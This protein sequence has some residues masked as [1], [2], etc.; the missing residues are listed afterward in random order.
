MFVSIMT[1][2]DSIKK[3]EILKTLAELQIGSLNL[4]V[5]GVSMD[6]ALRPLDRVHLNRGLYL[7]GDI[8]V[9]VRRDFMVIHRLIGWWWYQG[10]WHL[11]TKGDNLE[12]IDALVSKDCIIGKVIS[13]ERNG[14]IFS[15]TFR[16]RFCKW[17]K[18]IGGYIVRRATRPRLKVD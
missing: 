4:T 9:Y 5:Q 3:R 17:L 13:W 6:P 15:E 11:V 2:H 12:H 8:L 16:Q 10:A 7:P 1:A 14:I 18:N